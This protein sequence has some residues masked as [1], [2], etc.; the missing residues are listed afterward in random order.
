MRYKINLGF[1]IE[2]TANSDEEFLG[3]LRQSFDY[4]KSADNAFLRQVALNA[5]ECTGKSISYTDIAS[6]KRSLIA[7]GA[8]EVFDA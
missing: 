5:C 4:A 6:C 7:A 8:M 2:F 3:T 1:P